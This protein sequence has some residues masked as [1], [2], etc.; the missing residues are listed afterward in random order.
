MV[1]AGSVVAGVPWK[2]IRRAALCL[3]RMLLAERAAASGA[4]DKHVYVGSR[5]WGDAREAQ[6]ASNAKYTCTHTYTFIY[7]HASTACV[8]PPF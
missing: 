2:V 8:G 3:L 1:L 7:G 6:I 4:Y 5:S